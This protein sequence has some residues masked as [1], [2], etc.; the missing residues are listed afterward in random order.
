VYVQVNTSAEESKDGC[1]PAECKD[2]V[3]HVVAQCG[4]L[5]FCGLMT[6]GKL[7]DTTSACFD[8]LAGIRDELLKDGELAK[9]CPP[10]EAFEL[11]MGMSGDFELAVKSGSTNVRIGSTIFG[12]RQPKKE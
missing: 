8:M 9:L 3:Q 2:V 7:G 1:E 6:I 11:S 10:P 4:N 12:H 5:R